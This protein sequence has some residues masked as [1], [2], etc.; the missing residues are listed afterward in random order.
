VSLLAFLRRRREE[1]DVAVV[2]AGLPA[3]VVALE[4][5]RRSRRVSVLGIAGAEERPRG[6]GLV[7]LGPGR[8]YA[9]LVSALGRDGAR[10]LWSAGRENLERLRRFLAE[11]RN[12]CGYDPRGSFLLGADREEA[13]ALARGEDLLRDD[14]FPGEFMDHYMLETHFDLSGFAGAYWEAHGGELDAARLAAAVASA[15][16]A[17]GASFRPVPVRALHAGSSGAVVETDV[18]PVRAAGVV[19]ATDAPASD[20]LPELGASLREAPP[21]R[22]QA[23]LEPGA[24]LPTAARTA[25]G[26]CAWQLRGGRLTLAS[27]AAPSAGLETGLEGMA[28]RLP[29]AAEGARRW[30]EATEVTRDGLPTVGR[31]GRR[32]LAVAC[33][34]GA[35]P[36][37]LSFAAAAWVADAVLE[38]RDPTPEVFRPDRHTERTV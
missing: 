26:R 21:Q 10:A 29:V 19:L 3:L 15:A 17:A 31:L 35:L 28:A 4:L 8:P 7:V 12:D 33:G 9:H 38:G 13:E 2:G 32:P 20:L 11:V 16:R 24:S 1:A 25:D 23:S 5:A 6:L 37:S 34:F 30:T 22:L 27:T 36:A 14:E 18:G